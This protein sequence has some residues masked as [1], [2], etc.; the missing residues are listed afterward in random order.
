LKLEAVVTSVGYSDFLAETL[1]QNK[2]LFDKIVVVTSPE[3]DRTQKLCEHLFVECVV[4]DEFRTAEGKFCKGAGINA[5]LARLDG[6][7]WVV[8]LD[9]DIALPPMTR[10]YLEKLDLDPRN[11][12][13]CDRYLVDADEWHEHKRRPRLEHENGIYVHTS[14]YKIGAR[15]VPVDRGGYVP[16]GFFQLWNPNV[17]GVH[18]YPTSHTTAART[19]MLFSF[20]WPPARRDFLPEIIAY[21]L[22]SDREAPQGANWEGRT[23]PPFERSRWYRRWRKRFC[24][25]WRPRRRH[26][27]HRP[28]VPPAPPT[29][30]C[31]S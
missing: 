15:I 31:E 17:S 11:L 16:I 5:G 26:H 6:D 8:H 2:Q 14:A 21:H 9:A 7:G 30:Y 1:V 22:E 28:P 4:T 19:D 18:L 20:R 13:G 27:R 10:R 12:Y 3:D 25:C 24:W 23:T 29:P